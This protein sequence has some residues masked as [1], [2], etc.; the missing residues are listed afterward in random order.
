[1]IKAVIFDMYETLI[2]SFESPLYFGEQIA[3]DA[4]IPPKFFLKLW[5][6]AERERATG[7]ISLEKILEKITRVYGCFSEEKVEMIVNKRIAS[8]KEAFNHL[9]PE[10][11]PLL[12]TIKK[13]GKK[14]GL[15]SNCYS[16]EAAVIKKSVLFPYFDAVCLSYDEGLQKPDSAIFDRCIKKLNVSAE[17][18]IYVGD[19]DYNELAAAKEN[20]MTPVQAVWY[21][22]EGTVHPVKRMDNYMA[23]EKPL[24]IL[25]L[26]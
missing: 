3:E 18:C 6:S 5:R 7:K 2:T 22:K 1:M 24:D 23:A 26:F 20:G 19:G 16:E 13:S 11:I 10:I 21:L 8:K 25:E 15:I 14:L 9:H 12:T 17:E 4:G